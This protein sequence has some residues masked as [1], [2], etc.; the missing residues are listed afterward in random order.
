MGFELRN[1]GLQI[2][3]DRGIA[4]FVRRTIVPTVE[5][6]LR[7]REIPREAVSH[8]ILHPGGRRVI[9]VMAEKLGLGPADLAATEAVLAEHGNMSSVTVLFVLDEVLRTRKP[10]PGSLGLL[11]AFGPGFGAE[12]A[13]V[14]F[15]VSLVPR[16]RRALHGAGPRARSTLPSSSTR[17]CP[18][19]RSGRAWRTC[20]S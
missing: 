2:V 4:P 7:S 19:A 18:R 14:E 17:R 1:T 8:F 6:F 13:L 20:G 12:L 5:D 10:A 3:L 16:P 15:A 9:E 11:G